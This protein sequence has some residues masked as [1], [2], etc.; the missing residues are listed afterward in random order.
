MTL[1]PTNPS[2]Y[3]VCLYS[4]F[5]AGRASEALFSTLPPELLPLCSVQTDSILQ[6]NQQP[7]TIGKICWLFVTVWCIGAAWSFGTQIYHVSETFAPNA[8]STIKV[9]IKS[10][11]S[12]LLKQIGQCKV[13]NFI[14]TNKQ[15]ERNRDERLKKITMN[16]KIITS[17]HYKIQISDY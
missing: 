10:K 15:K 8:Y 13:C 16:L 4:D 11:I 2:P 12:N 17:V 7:H 3:L 1:I 6:Q 14:K 9:E 5:N